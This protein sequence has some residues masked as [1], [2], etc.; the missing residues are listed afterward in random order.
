[1]DIHEKINLGIIDE[2]RRLGIKFAFPTQT[3]HLAGKNADTEPF[4]E[5][6]PG[7]LT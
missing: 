5:T 1:M 4:H 7:R 2:F 3:V 6:R